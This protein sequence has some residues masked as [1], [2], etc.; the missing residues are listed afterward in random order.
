[1][2]KIDHRNVDSLLEEA[3]RNIKMDRAKAETALF[4]LLDYLREQVDRNEKLGMVAAKYLETL[5]RSN[6]QLVK[7]VEITRKR[8][9]EGGTVELTSDDKDSIFDE[10]QEN[11]DVKVEEEEN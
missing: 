7:V 9:V 1:L 3:V 2:K 4:P 10:L 5:Q 6:E 8:Q 11:P